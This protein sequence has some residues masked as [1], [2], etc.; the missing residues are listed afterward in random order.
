MYQT[1]T[2]FIQPQSGTGI[3]VFPSIWTFSA[4]QSYCSGLFPGTTLTPYPAPMGLYAEP[5]ANFT[6]VIFASGLMDPIRTFSPQVI[7][8]VQFTSIVSNVTFEC[9]LNV[10]VYLLF[11]FIYVSYAYFLCLF[12]T[13]EHLRG[14][15]RTTYRF[16]RTLWGYQLTTVSNCGAACYSCCAL[17]RVRNY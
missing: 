5:E 7:N 8:I 3:F 14:R 6:N 2:E 10:S 11:H 16:L 9:N 1:C 12:H 17:A 13:E 4:H 15:H